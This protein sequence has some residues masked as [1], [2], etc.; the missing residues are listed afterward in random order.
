MI[1]LTEAQILAWITPLLWTGW[2]LG[3]LC[4]LVPAIGLHWLIAFA[5]VGTFALGL[6]MHELPL[7][8]QKLK[9]YSWHKWA[10][11]T[12]LLLSA[13]RLLWRLTHTPPAD[14]PLGPYSGSLLLGS[15]NSQVTVPFTFRCP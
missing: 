15:D 9:L 7:S 10:G 12:I 8:P 5:I 11:V 14:L 3:M 6:Y 4:L 13:L 2:G 1:S